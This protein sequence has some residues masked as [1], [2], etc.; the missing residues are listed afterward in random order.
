M[1]I[2][3][4]LLIM[5]HSVLNAEMILNVLA[6]GA[7]VPAVSYYTPGAPDAYRLNLMGDASI[8]LAGDEGY[9]H[10]HVFLKF[11]DQWVRLSLVNLEGGE[12]YLHPLL[13]AVNQN[14]M[15]R[16]LQGMNQEGMPEYQ[17]LI[18]PVVLCDAPFGGAE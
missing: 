12:Y 5:I 13:D 1:K 4:T 8:P 3:L 7:A 17:E 9:E 15:M 16:R 14:C 10:D 6:A 11:A 2:L 18:L